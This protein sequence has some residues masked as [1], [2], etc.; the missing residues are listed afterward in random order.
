M[1][2]VLGLTGG[3]GLSSLKER[4]IFFF[5]CCCLV[6]EGVTVIILSG[7]AKL[8]STFPTV[9]LSYL[10]LL[11]NGYPNI[12]QKIINKTTLV[13]NQQLFN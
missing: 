11:Q 7:C 4:N 8:W 10:S 12:S 13:G 3:L 9:G 1:P 6:L 5:D 2:F